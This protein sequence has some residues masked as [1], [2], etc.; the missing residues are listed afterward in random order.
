MKDPIYYYTQIL[1]PNLHKNKGEFVFILHL[2]N[3]PSN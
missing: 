1:Y 2:F 3:I